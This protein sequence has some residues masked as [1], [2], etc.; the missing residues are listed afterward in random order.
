MLISLLYVY[1]Y[2]QGLLDPSSAAFQAIGGCMR[3]ALTLHV[4]AAGRS[5]VE[6]DAQVGPGA[7]QMHKQGRRWGADTLVP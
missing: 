2:L 3:A 6:S 4:L 5:N 1:V 7:E